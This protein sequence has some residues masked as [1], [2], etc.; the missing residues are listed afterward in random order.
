MYLLLLRPF[1]FL[2]NAL[3][4]ESTPNQMA[5]G[6]ALGVAVGFVP[7]G[8]LL[9]LILV[10]ILGASRVNLGA[11]ALATFLVSWLAMLVDPLLESVGAWLLTRESLH[12]TW[13]WMYNAPVLPWTKFNHAVVLGGFVVGLA[14]VYPSYRL[15]RPLF[16]KYAPV[17]ADRVRKWWIARLLWGTDVGGRIGSVASV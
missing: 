15:S 12:S 3:S 5:W 1:R 2:A 4:A 13:T 7:K 11:G 8:N 16:E 6:F 17:V 10:T 9:A 14:A